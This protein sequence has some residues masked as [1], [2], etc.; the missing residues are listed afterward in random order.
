MHRDPHGPCRPSTGT[1]SRV[2]PASQ[3][4]DQRRPASPMASVRPAALDQRGPTVTTTA[5]ATTRPGRAPA[6]SGPTT[7]EHDRDG[8]HR[9]PHH[10]R[11]GVLGPAHQRDVE[12][13]QPGRRDADQPQP[14]HSARPGQRPPA[15]ARQHEQR[16]GGERVTHCL[17]GQQRGV[18][19]RPDTA[20]LLPTQA[21]PTLQRRTTPDA[22][23]LRFEC[24]HDATMGDMVRR[25][26]AKLTTTE[27]PCPVRTSCS[28]TRPSPGGRPDGL[29][30]RRLRPA[31]ADGRLPVGRPAAGRPALA[32]RPRRLPRRRR[33]GL[34]AAGR[35]GPRS[36][37]G[38][39]VAA[40]CWPPPSPHG[41]PAG[42]RRPA[43][44]P[45]DDRPLARRAGP[46]GVPPGGL[47]ARRTGGA[48]RHPRPTSA[49]A[50]RAGTPALR[51]ASPTG[52]PATAGSART[53]TGGHR[54]RRGAG[55]GL[56]AQVLAARGIDASRGARTRARRRPRPARA[57]GD[58]TPPV[59]VD[60]D[61]MRV[62]ELR[63]SGARAV[64]LTPA[65]QFPTGVVLAAD[66]PP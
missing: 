50:T 31:I 13:H 10:R 56:L 1:A 47:A 45:A 24:Q 26:R 7:R 18:D 49:T 6:S 12:H 27:G 23:S 8:G 4:Q 57:L 33:R 15:T 30:R 52:W 32:G 16:A 44:G 58:A 53:R 40:P 29:A 28:S 9:H 60:D 25:T 55:A 66:A 46:G 65:H 19:E 22:G 48:A 38:R 63:A 62:D 34:P 59:P 43:A 61:G 42:P 37:A 36:A 51:A 20:T 41:A 5:A 11:L 14:L 2:K 54:R 17:G 35:G 3:S 64:V 39:G 21:M